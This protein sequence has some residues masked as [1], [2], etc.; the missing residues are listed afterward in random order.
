MME[1]SLSVFCFDITAWPGWMVLV[2]GIAG[3][4]STFL[5]QG[6]AHELVFSE[7]HVR[8][9]LAV[10]TIQFLCYCSFSGI[11]FIR[12]LIGSTG[13][14]CPFSQHLITSLALCGS[15][16]LGNFALS[17]LSFPTQVLFR[18]SKMIPVMIGGM[19]FL[20]KRYSMIEMLSVVILVIGLVGISMS[21][22]FVHNK[23][24]MNGLVVVIISLVCDAVASN[25]QE[26]SLKSFE[27]PQSEVIAM[28]YF[29]GAVCLGTI[30]TLQGEFGSLWERC[31]AEPAVLQGILLLSMLGATG[32]EFVYLMIKAFGSLTAVMVTSLRKAFTVCLSFIVF[33][34]KK[35]S[36]FHGV[37]IV[38]IAL[39]IGMNAYAKQAKKPEVAP[40][41]LHEN[42]PFLP[43]PEREEAEPDLSRSAE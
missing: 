23:I 9:V 18:S 4:F 42:A 36:L 26:K 11:F 25:M 34:N 15:M 43:V 1:S 29:I 24:D 13:L 38:V 32:V 17:L 21:D 7:Y 20:K 40:K 19:I 41:G 12:L 6:M 35:F 22:K 33:A 27:A 5:V 37:S 10:T 2:L 30:A 8:E 31:N 14:K 28:I 3:I 39:G 16:L